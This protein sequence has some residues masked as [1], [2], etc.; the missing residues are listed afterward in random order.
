METPTKQPQTAGKAGFVPVPGLEEMRVGHAGLYVPEIEEQ[1]DEPISAVTIEASLPLG[2]PGG[3]QLINCESGITNK[4]KELAKDKD[5]HLPN[6]IIGVWVHY[7]TEGLIRDFNTTWKET[8]RS[9]EI[10]QT[11]LKKAVSQGKRVLSKKEKNELIE[12]TSWIYWSKQIENGGIS[13][14][15]A[16]ASMQ[17]NI[18]IVEQYKQEGL[19]LSPRKTE[20]VSFFDWRTEISEEWGN[21]ESKLKIYMRHNI[22]PVIPCLISSS[23]SKVNMQYTNKYVRRELDKSIIA[24]IGNANQKEFIADRIEG[25]ETMRNHYEPK[26]FHIAKINQSGKMRDRWFV[27]DCIR[28]EDKKQVLLMW[29]KNGVDGIL[30]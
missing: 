28:K 2:A 23:D 11:G 29:D 22:V 27:I 1:T 6:S 10:K 20:G 18:A 9:L 8:P 16:I 30:E 15:D 12:K 7:L 19:F 4:V 24:G 21:D 13:M 14:E 25:W 5:N 17:N 26:M 3:K